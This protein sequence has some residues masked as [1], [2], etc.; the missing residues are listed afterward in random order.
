M[1]KKF[2]ALA[3]ALVIGCVSAFAGDVEIQFIDS[4]SSDEFY[5][6]FADADDASDYF[7]FDVEPCDD[8]DAMTELWEVMVNNVSN[9]ED[10]T[11]V[12]VADE[13]VI[14]LCLWGSG[15]YFGYYY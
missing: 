12:M 1:V 6:T 3:A 15:F 5:D 13:D 11:V 7:G 10:E 8:Y 2:L 4:M 14:Y 9:V